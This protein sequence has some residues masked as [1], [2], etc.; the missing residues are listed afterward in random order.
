MLLLEVKDFTVDEDKQLCFFWLQNSKIFIQ[1]C[2]KTVL[3][4][5]KNVIEQYNSERQRGINK[6][7]ERGGRND[8]VI[9]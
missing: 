1:G 6:M 7:N 5:W 2:E 3:T 4:H 8:D 9:P